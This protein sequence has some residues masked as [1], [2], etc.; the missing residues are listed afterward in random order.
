MR[1][2]EN[3]SRKDILNY[4]EIYLFEFLYNFSDKPWAQ[5][6]TDEAAKIYVQRSPRSFLNYF[7]HKPWAQPYIEEAAKEAAKVNPIRFLINFS[8]KPWAQPYIDDAA[9]GTAKKEPEYFMEKWA[10]RFP[11]YINLA[12]FALG[13]ENVSKSK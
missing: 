2:N 4:I 12:L 13:S 1:L 8:N 3:S 11:Q 5:P 6:Y 9:K 10:D 7:S